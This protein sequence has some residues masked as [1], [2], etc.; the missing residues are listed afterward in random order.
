[1]LDTFSDEFVA[2]FV[3]LVCSI[4]LSFCWTKLH[5]VGL[6]THFVRLKESD[7]ITEMLDY[8]HF[9][10]LKIHFVGMALC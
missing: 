7:Q 5:S 8:M 1:M 3:A 4:K 10:G 2:K 6:K 9:V